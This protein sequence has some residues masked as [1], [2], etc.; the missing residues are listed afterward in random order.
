MA[1]TLDKLHLALGE[2]S[3]CFHTEVCNADSQRTTS[4]AWDNIHK[5]GTEAQKSQSTYRQVQN[6]LKCLD[7]KPEYLA[8]LH[9]IGDED[10]KVSGDLTDERRFGQRSDT[11]PWFWMT[12][13]PV[14]TSGSQMQECK[15]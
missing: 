14:G 10:L 9:D 8:T 12:G 15:Y 6:T 5:L 13:E 3:L 2:K 7:I 1:D 11:L 4:Q